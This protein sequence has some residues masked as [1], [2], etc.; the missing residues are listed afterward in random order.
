MENTKARAICTNQIYIWN[1]KG[2]EITHLYYN[3]CCSIWI[4]SQNADT[5]QCPLQYHLVF[6]LRFS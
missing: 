4:D 6:P 2:Q 3:S 1:K 5:L